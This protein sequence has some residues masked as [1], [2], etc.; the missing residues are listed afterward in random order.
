M[1]DIGYAAHRRYFENY[2]ATY[3][4][5]EEGQHLRKLALSNDAKLLIFTES[6]GQDQLIVNA[7]LR[8]WV[9]SSCRL[10]ASFEN[11]RIYGECS[12]RSLARP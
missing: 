6:R 8:D 11:Y 4:D 12:D 9:T 3:G 10:L 5:V 7:P 1:K 2:A